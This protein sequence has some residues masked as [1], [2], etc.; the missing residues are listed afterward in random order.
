LKRSS[1]GARLDAVP[2][3]GYDV[4][5]RCTAL[6]ERSAKIPA[7]HGLAIAKYAAGREKDLAFTRALARRGIVTRER[8]LALFEK[9]SVSRK[10][11]K[12]SGATSRRISIRRDRH[13][14]SRPKIDTV[15]LSWSNAIRPETF[16][17]VPIVKADKL[18]NAT[19]SRAASPRPF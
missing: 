15:K 5:A 2:R 9:T 16:N 13:P 4:A 6:L 12:E 8:L 10:C 18:S 14:H 19:R 11:G 1:A 17:A 3:G 7:V